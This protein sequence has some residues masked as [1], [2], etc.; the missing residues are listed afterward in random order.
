M[1]ALLRYQ[2]TSGTDQFT[3]NPTNGSIYLKKELDF[4]KHQSHSVGLTA[5]DGGKPPLVGH[6][7]L[8]V[9][10]NNVND[11]EPEIDFK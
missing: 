7:S 4:E 2:L 8:T 6:A 10:V 11:N 3:I 1:N 5:R 9:N